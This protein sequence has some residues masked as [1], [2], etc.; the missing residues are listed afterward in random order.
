MTRSR[1]YH[2]RLSDLDS[3]PPCKVCG[4]ESTHYCNM[5]DE[6]YCMEHLVGHDENEV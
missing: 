4:K 2:S 6:Y 3:G 1:I 5:N